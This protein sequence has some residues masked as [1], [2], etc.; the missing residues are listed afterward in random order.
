MFVENVL[1]FI[2][3]NY[4]A[5]WTICWWRFLTLS[6][7]SLIIYEHFYSQSTMAFFKLNELES[8][9]IRFRDIEEELQGSKV[10]L[11]IFFCNNN[12]MMMTRTTSTIS[13]LFLFLIQQYKLIF[14]CLKWSSVWSWIA[15]YERKRSF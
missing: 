1:T 7:Y 8:N 5:I 4:K 9:K 11:N 6:I 3:I 2:R 13:F 10:S 14:H 12:L 15:K